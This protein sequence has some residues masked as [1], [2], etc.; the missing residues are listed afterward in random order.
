MTGRQ[1]KLEKDFDYSVYTLYRYSISGPPNSPFW[2][3]YKIIK[4][5]R[6][7]D[8]AYRST[9]VQDSDGR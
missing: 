3:M 1:E 8:R 7:L 9:F 6:R 5:S 4:F 2:V